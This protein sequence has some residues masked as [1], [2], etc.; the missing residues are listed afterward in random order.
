MMTENNLERGA[1][2]NQYRPAR[3]YT[4][5]QELVDNLP[6]LLMG[7]CGGVLFLAG[8]GLSPLGWLVAASYLA[9]CAAGALWI[10]V[11][12][13]PH[14]QHYGTR[15]CPC[16][17]GQLSAKLAPKRQENRFARQFRK[18]IP[19]IVPLWVIPVIA[20][21]AFYIRY[22]SQGMLVLLIVFVIDAFVL[23]PLVSRLYGCGHCPQKTDC[24]WMVK[25]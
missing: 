21:I 2:C 9:Y 25:G 20:G 8:F 14:C 6:Y 22:R 23:L 24:P 3:E 12:V 4:H 16:G 1:T 7:L 18:H 5:F 15:V 11:F 13:C 19:V 17:Y 10:I